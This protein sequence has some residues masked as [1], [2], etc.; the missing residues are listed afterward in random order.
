ML[1]KLRTIKH[2]EAFFGIIGFFYIFALGFFVV[3]FVRF[4]VHA[5]GDAF[6]TQEKRELLPPQFN[7]GLVELSL[8]T[9]TTQK[10]Q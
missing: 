2:L 4:L 10:S 5:S 7:T 9:T 1:K 3:Y 6:R 8:T